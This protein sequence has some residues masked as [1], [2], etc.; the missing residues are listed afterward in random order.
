MTDIIIGPGDTP[1]AMVV[2]SDG[3]INVTS[4][5]GGSAVS[6]ASPITTNSSVDGVNVYLK[7]PATGLDVSY[8]SP[9]TVVGPTA[10]G[11]AAA[12]PPVLT[13][14]TATAGAT[15][16][17]QVI[18]VDSSGF[19][20]MVG[21]AASGAAVAGNPVFIGGRAA[22]TEPTVVTD[23]QAI[24][25]QLTVTG[26][27]VVAPYSIKEKQVRGKVTSTD[28]GAHTVIAAG[29]GTDKTYI[30]SL[31]MGR[32]DSG[33]TPIVVTLSDD[34][35]TPIVV[36]PGGATNITFPVPLV[37]AAATAFTIT[38]GTAVTTLYAAA[39]GYYGS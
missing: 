28:T 25:Q 23:G 18:K 22:S 33:T 14:G 38:S 17:V 19:Q 26:K 11:S 3:S 2:N 37:T 13:A 32:T 39:Q 9:N 8:S 29:S 12:N 7:D 5:S 4:T 35:S 6:I 30:T 36:P 27:T 24:G 16:N 20:Y 15:G 10:V 31:Q 21:A 34:Q 1:Y